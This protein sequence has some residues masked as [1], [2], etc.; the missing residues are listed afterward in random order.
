MLI[1]RSKDKNR[2]SEIKRIK[3][4]KQKDPFK[5]MTNDERLAA[6]PKDWTPNP[7]LK[8]IPGKKMDHLRMVRGIEIKLDVPQ[9]MAERVATY[10]IAA[11]IDNPHQAYAEMAD[12]GVLSVG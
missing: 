1:P 2:R 5:Y 7:G 6:R 12:R 11:K 4:D 8:E 3:A 10:M 9:A